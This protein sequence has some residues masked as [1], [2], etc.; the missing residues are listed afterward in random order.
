VFRE[1]IIID[2]IPRLVPGWTKPVIIGRH[3]F[4]D[5]YKATDKVVTEPGKF[6]LKFVPENGGKEEEIEAY[7]FKGRGVFLGMYNTDESIIA[8]A[9][10][11]FQYALKR[12]YP[13]YMSTKN[14]I[15]KKYDGRFKDI[16]EETYQS[17]YK[18]DFETQGIWYE[19]RLI[20]DMVAY[21]MKSEGGY[22]WACKNYDGDVQSD[23]L[24]QGYG[25]LG[26]MTSVLVSPDGCI[27]SEAA[28]GT[29]TRHFRNHQKGKETSTN[30]V[31]SIYA[32]TRGLAHRAK[33]DENEGLHQ[34]CQKLEDAVIGTIKSGVMTKDLA[35]CVKGTNDVSRS[36]YASTEEF[37]SKIKE[38]FDATWTS[39]FKAKL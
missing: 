7:N 28:H 10:S 12:K 19:H 8:F 36:D 35:I 18:K 26:L 32:W 29:V 4:G 3:A 27:E 21:C 22:V 2:N 38:N 16:F 24:A 39:N 30:P 23:T 33:L 6:I 9:H 31:A 14:T 20:D 5:Q 13:L 37:M 11:C 25:S 17:T 15:L 1:P 34:F